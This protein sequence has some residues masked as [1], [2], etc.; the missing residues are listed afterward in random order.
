MTLDQF[1]NTKGVRIISESQQITTSPLAYAR[2]ALRARDGPQ[3]SSLSAFSRRA[4]RS[5]SSNSQL[6]SLEPSST[7]MTSNCSGYFLLKLLCSSAI[8]HC[9]RL[10]RELKA[11]TMTLAESVN[12]GKG[13]QLD[14]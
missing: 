2:P 4:S 11:G 7:T 1:L 5:C 10:V 13:E 3:W 6:P 14:P 9:S 8:K 12:S